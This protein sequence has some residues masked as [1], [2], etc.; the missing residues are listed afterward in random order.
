MK[1]AVRNR[2]RKRKRTNVRILGV[3]RII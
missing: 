3:S 1:R 2:R